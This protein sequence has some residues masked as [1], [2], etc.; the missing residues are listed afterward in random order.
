MEAEI[1]LRDRKK[2][3]VHQT[4]VDTAIRLFEQRGFDGVTVDEIAAAADVSRRTFFR[5]FPTKEAVVF[6]RRNEQL[7]QFREVLAEQPEGFDAIRQA[8]L[9]LSTDYAERRRQILAEQKLIRTAP[10]LMMHDLEVDRAF[11]AVMVEH[12]LDRSRR[13]VTDR[14]RAKLL[15]AAIMGATR[16]IIEEWAERDGDADLRKLGTEALDLL[17]PLAPRPR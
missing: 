1:G 16:V 12:L 6:A 14:R 2:L 15:A 10:S 9:G 13:T 4:L 5:Y 11:E 7:A 3:R 17:E 8:L